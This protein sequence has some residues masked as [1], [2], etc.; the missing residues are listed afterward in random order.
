MR[1]TSSFATLIFVAILAIGGG[2]AFL[3]YNPTAPATSICI[4]VIAFVIALIAFLA[5]GSPSVG[6]GSDPAPG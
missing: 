5:L 1:T 3:T 2:L 6:Q 4:G